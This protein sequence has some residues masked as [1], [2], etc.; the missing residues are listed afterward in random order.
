MALFWLEIHDGFRREAAAVRAGGEAYRGG[1]A[2]P[3]RLAAATAPRLWSLVVH[4]HGH[5]QIEDAHYFPSFRRAD[6]RL[7]PG[8]DALE[9]DHGKLCECVAACIEAANGLD[10]ALRVNGDSPR[11]D[12]PR[13]A[14]DRFVTTTE[15]LTRRLLRHLEDEE[16]LVIPLM[17]D[18]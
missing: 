6:A 13:H 18:R 2:D 1:R 8:I 14:A 11:A 5:H 16:D 17:L 12:A 7:A 4:L 15:L 3:E 10:D 9:R